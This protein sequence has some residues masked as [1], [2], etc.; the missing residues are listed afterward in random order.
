MCGQ[1]NSRWSLA[2]VERSKYFILPHLRIL[3]TAACEPREAGT[4]SKVFPALS[5]LPEPMCVPR[6]G[7]TWEATWT[8]H[9]GKMGLQEQMMCL[10]SQLRLEGQYVGTGNWPWWDLYNYKHYKSGL[11]W[12]I[13]HF[14]YSTPLIYSILGIATCLHNLQL[15]AAIFH[16]WLQS[17]NSFLHRPGNTTPDPAF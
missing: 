12:L 6:L 15:W 16:G 9:G 4:M 11:L 1:W 17:E 3:T 14:F 5:F 2:A 8:C 7:A 13:R 10:S